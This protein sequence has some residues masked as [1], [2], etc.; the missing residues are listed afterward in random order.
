MKK[1]IVSPFR[2]LLTFKDHIVIFVGSN[3]NG[4]L[5]FLFA[6]ALLKILDKGEYNLY[7]AYASFA[8]VFAA[9]TKILTN[10]ATTYGDS[11]FDFI[12]KK[13]KLTNAKLFF[14]GILLFALS[15]VVIESAIN[16]KTVA[17]IML[18]LS[19]VLQIVLAITIGLLQHSKSF[20]KASV[21]RIIQSFTKVSLG[22][23][24]YFLFG[25]VGI[26]FGVLLSTII[27]TLIV[28][29]WI[30]DKKAKELEY[31]E[32]ET[33]RA[34]DIFLNLLLLLLLELLFNIDTIFVLNVLDVDSAH[35][36]NSLVLVKKSMFFSVAG[37]SAIILSDARRKGV[38]KFKKLFQN[39][40]IILLTGALFSSIFIFGKGYVLE[41]LNLG[42]EYSHIYDKFILASLLYVVLIVVI[43]WFTYL[44]DKRLR[45]LVILSSAL[46][47]VMYSFNISTIDHIINSFL[48]GLT[49]LLGLY[50]VIIFLLKHSENKQKFKEIRENGT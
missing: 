45:I 24:F 29:T 13:L 8:F 9:P 2:K 20:V 11:L 25:F 6:I 37:F 12:N 48:I 39:L 30:T 46:F 5:N 35:V 22:I 38:D 50:G 47:L 17:S 1:V 41:F 26:W 33:L 14:L 15:A 36:Y 49:I 23:V 16:G 42:S 21:V 18:S 3:T 43:T 32:Y 44:E 31:I 40:I 19:V 27:S 7:T 4:G 28:T 34:S 10:L